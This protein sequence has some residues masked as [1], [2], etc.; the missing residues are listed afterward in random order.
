MV[1]PKKR[2]GQH[3]LTDPGIAQ[4]ICDSLHNETSVPVVE[5]GPGK[6][7]LTSILSERFPDFLAVETDNEALDYL[8]EKYPDLKDKIVHEDFLRFDPDRYISGRFC[9]ISNLPYNISSPVMFSM[10]D[11]R[12]RI[13]EAVFMLQKEVARRLASPHGTKEYG[14]LSVLLQAYYDV[15]YLFSVGEGSFFPPPKVKSGVVRFERVSG[16]EVPNDHKVFRRV[17]KAAFNQRRKTLRNSLKSILLPLSLDNQPW[18]ALRPE[19]IS[20]EEFVR[21]SNFIDK[22]MQM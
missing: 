8:K 14:V 18:M 5:I 12:D 15:R 3:F 10:L 22:K 1:K 19:Q 2:Y 21:I 11:Q 4:R 20:V 13:P 9:L 7:V 16:K 17:V 6:G